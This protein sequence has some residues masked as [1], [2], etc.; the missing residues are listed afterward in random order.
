MSS[1]HG[2]EVGHA[3]VVQGVVDLVEVVG[4]VGILHAVMH[5]GGGMERVA[6]QRQQLVQG[7]QVGAGQVV[8][9]A[10][11]E[12]AGV[13]DTAVGIHQ[14]ARDLLPEMRTSSRYSTEETHGRTISAPYLSMSSCGA[15]DVA[16]GLGHLAAVADPPHRRGSARPC[17]A[18]RYGCLRPPAGSCGTSRGAGPSLPDTG[19]QARRA[20]GGSPARRRSWYRRSTHRVEDVVFLFPVLAA[21]VGALEAFGHDLF[22]GRFIPVVAARGV[23]GEAVGHLVHPLGVVPGFAAVLAERGP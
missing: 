20:R 21:A 3:I 10:Q 9:G 6:V 4:H 15:D 1:I 5:L 16:D 7:Q 2:R 14:S 11:D 17:R 19:R 23:L 13:A 12:A 22:Q 8:D 18:D